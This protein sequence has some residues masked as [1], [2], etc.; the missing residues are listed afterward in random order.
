MGP[1]LPTGTTGVPPFQGTL[2]EVP[3]GPLQKE[4]KKEESSG[5]GAQQ[6]ELSTVQEHGTL[7]WTLENSGV[8]LSLNLFSTAGP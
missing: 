7:L 4:E 8:T 2:G 3:L 6:S 5:S 1:E